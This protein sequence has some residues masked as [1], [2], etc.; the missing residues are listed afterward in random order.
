MTD[1]ALLRLSRFI[2]HSPATKKQ[3]VDSLKGQKKKKTFVK[4][5]LFHEMIMALGDRSCPSRDSVHI[6]H[7]I[8]PRTSFKI[9]FASAVYRNFYDNKVTIKKICFLFQKQRGEKYNKTKPKQ[10]VSG[11]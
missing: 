5:C 6:N 2:Q 11:T 3:S 10:G 4:D 8:L 9:T 1:S 7:E